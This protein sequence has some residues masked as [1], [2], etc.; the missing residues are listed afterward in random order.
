[1][2]CMCQSC[3]RRFSRCRVCLE[4]WPT[5]REARRKPPHVRRSGTLALLYQTHGWQATLRGLQRRKR[6]AA[7]QAGTDADAAAALVHGDHLAALKH[8]PLRALTQPEPAAQP[9]GASRKPDSRPARSHT[10]KALPPEEVPGSPPPASPSEVTHA[11]GAK[12]NRCESI[13]C[14]AHSPVMGHAA[15][16]RHA[17]VF[18]GLAEGLSEVRLDKLVAQQVVAPLAHAHVARVHVPQR[19]CQ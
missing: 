11:L 8:Q 10:C 7:H 4:T 3:T 19:A 12:A 9:H 18:E 13:E 6:T 2:N 14:A 17:Q 1:M 15:L 16:N 5:G